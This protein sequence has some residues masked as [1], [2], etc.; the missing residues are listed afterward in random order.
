MR[1]QS[2]EASF[3]KRVNANVKDIAFQ[4]QFMLQMRVGKSLIYAIGFPD[5]KSNDEA[6]QLWVRA[7]YIEYYKLDKQARIRAMADDLFNQMYK[8]HQRRISEKEVFPS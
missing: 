6:V 8:Y 7:N 1:V 4:I 5:A 2:N 3:N